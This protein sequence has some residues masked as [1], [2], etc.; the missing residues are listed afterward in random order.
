MINFIKNLFQSNDT[1][2]VMIFFD[3]DGVL[4]PHYSKELD[5]LGYERVEGRYGTWH[6]QRQHGEWMKELQEAGA[7]LVW[8]TNW[9]EEANEFVNPYYGL[10]PFPYINYIQ[11]SINPEALSEDSTFKL[12]YIEELAKDKPLIIVDDDLKEDVYEWKEK[13]EAPTLI[14]SPHPARG[15]DSE[16]KEAMLDFVKQYTS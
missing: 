1:E 5:S 16:Q 9:G 8:E 12:P 13:R 7:T 14:I 3:I 4:H 6:L 15:W 10:H 11:T 2:E